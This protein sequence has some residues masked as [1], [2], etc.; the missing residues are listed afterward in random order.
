MSELLSSASAKEPRRRAERGASPERCLLR[1]EL[2]GRGAAAAR[3]KA[4][5]SICAM[6]AAAPAVGSRERD[7]CVCIVY[8][9]TYVREKHIYQYLA[10]ARESD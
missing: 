2:H 10:Q 7:G 6:D 9:L 5:N 4:E 8:G 1:N 3:L